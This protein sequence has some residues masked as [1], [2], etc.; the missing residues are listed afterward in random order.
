M[1]GSIYQA[2]L[3]FL[4]MFPLQQYICRIVC[5]T[6]WLLSFAIVYLLFIH[7]SGVTG[8]SGV[9]FIGGFDLDTIVTKARWVDDIYNRIIENHPSWTNNS[10]VKIYAICKYIFYCNK[11]VA[12][13]LIFSMIVFV[14]YIVKERKIPVLLSCLLTSSFISILL[15]IYIT[16]SGGSQMYFLMGMYPHAILAS[17]YAISHATSAY[18]H[19]NSVFF[20]KYIVYFLIAVFVTAL[21]VSV[22]Q[23]ISNSKGM[24][25]SGVKI[26]LQKYGF[27]DKE[28]RYS[29][30]YIDYEALLW[31]KNNTRCEDVIAVNDPTK[32]N[33]MAIG[34]FSQR[35]IWNEIKYVP[36]LEEAKRRNDIVDSIKKTPDSAIETMKKNGINYFL[37]RKQDT[38][39]ATN[40]NLP[41]TELVFE[42]SHYTI[43]R[44]I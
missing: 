28:V 2:L 30:D 44:F 43:Y 22:K 18:T 4:K 9:H 1:L 6:A 34:V 10:L 42:N 37:S 35:Y 25:K 32:E 8:D 20:Q 41:K 33:Y 39:N 12:F 27:I 40:S 3:L 14:L 16:Q 15:A 36:D 19:Q 24:A 13:M 7:S 17:C 23:Y 11:F 26:M 29:L 31:I 5:G 38:P 21:G